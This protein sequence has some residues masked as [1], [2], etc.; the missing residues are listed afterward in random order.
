MEKTT[1]FLIGGICVA[2]SL[3]QSLYLLIQHLRYFS[4]PDYQLYI[5]RIILMVPIYCITSCM[6]MIYPHLTEGLN[7][8]RDFYEAFVIYSFTMLLINF[9][10]GERRLSINLELKEHINHP[11]PFCI[12]FH[13]FHPGSM[14][15][16]LV[17]IGVLQFVIFRPLLSALSI[18]FQGFSIYH[19]GY[20]GFDDSYLYLFVLINI[21][22]TVALYGLLLFFVATEELLE[23]YRPLPKF[24]CIKGVIFFFFLAGDSIKHTAKHR[25]YNRK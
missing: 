6:S 11:W 10:G 1:A 2:I 19:E 3:S 5:G 23:P 16:R 8:I 18:M 9:V 13:S 17:K 15:L 22:F 25:S 20:F 24:I 4:K 21:S 12:F 14:F 7:M